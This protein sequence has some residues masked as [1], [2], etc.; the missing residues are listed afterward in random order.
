MTLTHVHSWTI[1]VRPRCKSKQTA[2]EHPKNKQTYAKG[3]NVLAARVWITRKTYLRE[4]F[5]FSIFLSFSFHLA[6]TLAQSTVSATHIPAGQNVD[7]EKRCRRRNEI[8]FTR[9]RGEL[10]MFAIFPLREEIE[11]K[12]KRKIKKNCCRCASSTFFFCSVQRS[13]TQSSNSMS[14][15]SSHKR[16]D[17]YVVFACS[18]RGIVCVQHHR[19]PNSV[20]TI[21]E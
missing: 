10:P 13:T 18:H 14:I 4:F 12:M 7:N 11:K 2:H 5:R 8:A 20:S 1:R 6:T 3:V 17:N 21:N 9:T 19:E 15:Q 16:H